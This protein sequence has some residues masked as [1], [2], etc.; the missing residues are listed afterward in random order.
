MLELLKGYIENSLPEKEYFNTNP[1]LTQKVGPARNLCPYYGNT[2]VFD[3]QEDTKKELRKLQEEL[4]AAAGWMLAKQLQ[5]ETFHMTLHSLHDGQELDEKLRRQMCKAEAEAKALLNQWQ[6]RPGLNMRAT[7]L[8]NMVR[9]SIVLGLEPADAESRAALEEMYTALEGVV[10]LNRKLT[11]HITM[12]Y[13][14]PGTYFP[15]EVDCLRKALHQV[16]L[17]VKLE[18]KDLV[19]QNF[20]DMNHYT[21]DPIFYTNS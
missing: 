8:F 12:A 7:W 5:P 16:R 17:Q 14:Y 9:T 15:Y 21:Q 10:P 18:M 2:V 11:P 13:F 6:D 19:L 4:Y 20:T 3:L 1:N